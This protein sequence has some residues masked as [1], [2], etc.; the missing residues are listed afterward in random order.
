VITMQTYSASPEPVLT[1]RWNCRRRFEPP[2]FRPSRS[3]PAAD[4]GLDGGRRNSMAIFQI[5]GRRSLLGLK[6]VGQAGLAGCVA[7]AL[8][9]VSNC[10]PRP[11]E[12]DPFAVCTTLP[13]APTEKGRSNSPLA[14]W[15]GSTYPGSRPGLCARIARP[16]LATQ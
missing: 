1:C 2:G 6:P 5:P 8:E 3:G 4:L 15:V 16:R 9:A 12:H 11:F 14:I 13:F 7:N 10:S